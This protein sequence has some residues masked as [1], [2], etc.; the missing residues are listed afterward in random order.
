MTPVDADG[1]GDAGT[2]VDDAGAGM[3]VRVSR[4]GRR[5]DRARTICRLLPVVPVH[6]V[7]VHALAAVRERWAAQARTLSRVHA[8][9]AVRYTCGCPLPPFFCRFVG[10]MA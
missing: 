8:Q 6:T 5:H 1:A 3:D 2:S 9:A 10:A 7:C 4:P